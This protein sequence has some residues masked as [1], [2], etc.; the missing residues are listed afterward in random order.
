M[1]RSDGV[2]NEVFFSGSKPARTGS[3]LSGYAV[4]SV[5]SVAGTWHRAHWTSSFS[6]TSFPRF[7]TSVSG[8]STTGGG[9]SPDWM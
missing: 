7:S 2:L 9:R 6:K 8:C 4:L 3:A 1:K 5:Y